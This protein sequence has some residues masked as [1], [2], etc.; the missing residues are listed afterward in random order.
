M[1]KITILS[2]FLTGLLSP[3]LS[4]TTLAKPTD[5]CDLLPYYN[6]VIG[7]NMDYFAYWDAPKENEKDRS[8]VAFGESDSNYLVDTP[9][10]DFLVINKE[11]N[12][13]DKP[14]QSRLFTIKEY[15]DALAANPDYQQ[16]NIRVG[17]RE[18]IM[19]TYTQKMEY[20]HSSGIEYSGPSKNYTET[21]VFTTA[22][23]GKLLHFYYGV[24]K[25]ENEICPFDAVLKSLR[26]GQ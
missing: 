22:F 8:T 23:D 25:G 4:N 24:P 1:K 9:G 17:G 16:T 20:A 5:S 12:F 3:G 26:F 11:E 6:P 15:A 10:V 21:R 7:L 19:V 18:A 14:G 2:L 13:V